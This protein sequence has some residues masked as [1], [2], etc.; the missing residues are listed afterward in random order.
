MANVQHKLGLWS[1]DTSALLGKLHAAQR[2][3]FEYVVARVVYHPNGPAEAY[4]LDALKQLIADASTITLPVYAWAYCYP[5]NVDQQIA[6][7]AACLPNPCANLVLG[8][9]RRVGES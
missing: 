4:Q 5:R 1:R 7:I 9:R 3:G 6:A 8:H 2:L